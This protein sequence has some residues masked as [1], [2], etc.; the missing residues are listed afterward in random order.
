[1]P[2]GVEKA[3]HT[4]LYKVIL[5]HIHPP[6]C[7]PTPDHVVVFSCGC[8]F[9]ERH[10]SLAW[11]FTWCETGSLSGLEDHVMWSG[12]IRCVQGLPYLFVPFVIS[13]REDVVV[14]V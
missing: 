12:I 14:R 13:K 10:K 8:V 2:N 7:I 1:M 11:V 3:T 9:H 4:C 6:D 5:L